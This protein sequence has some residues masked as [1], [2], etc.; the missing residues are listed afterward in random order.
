MTQTAN[1]GDGGCPANGQLDTLNVSP[2]GVDRAG[3]CTNSN[4]IPQIDVT[5]HGVTTTYA[6]T[7]QI[8]NTGGIDAGDLPQRHKH[9][10]AVDPHREFAVSAR[11]PHR[12]AVH[13]IA[14][15]GD[16]S[17]GERYLHE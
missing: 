4:I 2:H 7:G 1:G 11:R 8:L 5:V 16:D 9:V 3:V 12:H 17:D 15:G 6:D 13:P 10:H 14:R